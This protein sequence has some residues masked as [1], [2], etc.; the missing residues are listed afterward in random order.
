MSENFDF[1]IIGAGP[2]GHAAAEE[3]SKRGARVAIVEK[4]KW[5][6]T[7]AHLGCIPTKALLACSKRY[8]ELGKLKRLGTFINE[9]AFD[10]S[11]MKRH[12]AQMVRVAAMGV[13]KSLD[14]AGVKRLEGEGKIISPSEV[15]VLPA[16]GEKCR[17]NTGKILIACGSEPASIPGAAISSRVM[18]SNGFLLLDKLPSSVIVVGGGAIGLEF[19][20][21]LAELGVRVTL[22]E[23]LDQ[24]LPY[25]DKEAADALS[26]EL[27]KT[28]MEIYTSTGMSSLEETADG[29]FFVGQKGHEE[30]TVHGECALIC[31]GRKPLINRDELD[32]LG[33]A[34]NPKGIIVDD[35]QQTTVENIFALGDVTGGVLLAHRA[36]A[37]GKA[38]ANYLFGDG[39]FFYNKR[40]VPSVVYT[41]PG[42]SRVGLTEKAALEQGLEVEI[43]KAEYGAN[44]LARAELRGN[45]FVKILLSSGRLRG[46]TIVGDEAG[47]LIAAMSLAVAGGRAIR[48]L[49]QWIL[50]HPTLSELLK[51]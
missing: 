42:F 12:Q 1:V 21:F 16:K 17:L 19:G 14:D 25:E 41:H 28:G 30:I 22:F 35:R 49:R 9:T 43:R 23:L 24:I 13:Q 27:K 45:G 39:D 29:V 10:F 34:W 20:N 31:T 4:D 47:E 48:D 37:Q 18:N 40:V 5:G 36:T 15:E 26:L 11:A 8:A 38:L 51:F 6:G 33:I 46:A 32:R 3:A 7:C 2:G 44:L 50:P